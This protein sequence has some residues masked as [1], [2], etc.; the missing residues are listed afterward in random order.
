MPITGG[1]KFFEASKTLANSVAGGNATAYSTTGSA[2]ADH[3]IDRNSFT[4]WQSV[5]S[6]DGIREEWFVQTSELITVSRIFLLNINFKTVAV[7]Y[8]DNGVEKDFSGAVGLYGTTPSGIVNEANWGLDSAYYEVTPVVTS[9][10]KIITFST[11]IANEPRRMGTFI[12]TNELGT[13]VG[14]PDVKKIE[15]NKNIRVKKTLNGR[16]FVQKSVETKSYSIQFKNYPSKLKDDLDLAVS[17]FDSDESFIVWLCGGRFG[18]PFFGYELVGFRL[19]DVIT[20]Q[21]TNNFNDTYQKNYYNGGINMKI[22][23]SE[24]V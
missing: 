6:T 4:V 12:A 23:L 16:M 13:L 11:Q 2:S 3:A 10:L 14:F 5:E 15:K 17:L 24:S 20:M 18:D 22:D 9:L 7:H 19:S 21:V 1:I 8:F